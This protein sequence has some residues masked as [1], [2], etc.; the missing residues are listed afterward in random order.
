MNVDEVIR[1]VEIANEQRA[2]RKER[3]DKYARF[4]ASRRYR[5]ARYLWLTTLQPRPLRCSCCGAD[6]TQTRIVCDHIVP[7]RTPQ[8]WERRLDPTNFQLL[9]NDCNLAKGSHDQ[10]DWRAGAG[11]QIKRNTT[12]GEQH[13]DVR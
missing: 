5:A 13:A 2:A 7:I 8:G 4:Y 11:E 10:T 1:S 6:S 12:K 9:C 3:A